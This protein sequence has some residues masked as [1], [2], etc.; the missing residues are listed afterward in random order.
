LKNNFKQEKNSSK[1][2]IDISVKVLLITKQFQSITMTFTNYSC[3]S[4]RQL[5]ENPQWPSLFVWLSAPEL[6]YRRLYS[7][8]NIIFHIVR[9]SNESTVV[10]VKNIIGSSLL[11]LRNGDDRR[12]TWPNFTTRCIHAIASAHTQIIDRSSLLSA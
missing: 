6:F 11:R 4:Y 9:T 12:D 1:K 2:R 8:N 7:I 3:I 5:P 10:Y